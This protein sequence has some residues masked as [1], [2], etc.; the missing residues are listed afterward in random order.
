MAAGE[1]LHEAAD[2][3]GAGT[4]ARRE[5][6]Q[7]QPGDPPFGTGLERGHVRRLQVQAHDL[8]EERV[9]LGRCEP[10]VGG[11]H[12]EQLAAGPQPRSGNGGSARVVMARV[13]CGG[14][15]SS[16]NVMTSWT[17]AVSMTW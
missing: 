17:A 9:R 14:R 4:A 12:L 7:L 8:V 11:A 10:Q 13:T 6:R 5:R 2:V 15:L 16:R 1:R 3:A